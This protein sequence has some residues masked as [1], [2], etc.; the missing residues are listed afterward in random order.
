MNEMTNPIPAWHEDA[1]CMGEDPDLFMLSD[2]ESPDFLEFTGRHKPSGKNVL[3]NFNDHKVKTAQ[4]IC[5]ECPVMM[6]CQEESTDSDLEFTVRGGLRP[7]LHTVPAGRP[8]KNAPPNP[9]TNDLWRGGKECIRGHSGEWRYSR[10]RWTCKGCERL[11]FAEKY[12]PKERPPLP[13]TC[14]K[15]HNNWA[16]DGRGRRRCRTCKNEAKNRSRAAKLGA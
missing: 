12:E 14:S 3:W 16:T 5:L 2:A 10:S 11:S 4:D 8:K 7:L 9:D 1:N 13:E 15:G 6:R